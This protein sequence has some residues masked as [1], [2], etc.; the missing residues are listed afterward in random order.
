M[1]GVVLSP[2]AGF[3]VKSS[4]LQSAVYQPIEPDAAAPNSIEPVT[5]PIPVPQGQKVFINISWDQQ[6]PQPPEASEE[7]VRKA[8]M[9]EDEAWYVP[10]VVS[11]GRRDT[12]KAGKLS[13]VFD[14]IF[15]PSIKSRILRDPE[16]RL[17]IIEL[18]LQRI[19]AQTPLVLSR[20]IGTPNIAAKGKLLPRKVNLPSKKSVPS[21]TKP[22]IEEISASKPSTGLN[23]KGILKGLSAAEKSKPSWSWSNKDDRLE[24][25]ISVPKLASRQ[26]THSQ[27]PLTTLDLEPRRLILQVPGYE[28]MDINL[29]LSDAEIVATSGTTEY[30]ETEKSLLLKRQR[31]FDVEGAVSEWRAADGKLVLIA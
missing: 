5:G 22:L 28:T 23:P 25:T 17:F 29:N 2:T 26:L 20:E 21:T 27:I 31:R 15:H 19:E 1:A 13:L 30:S 11:E 18:A 4:T 7:V 12:D 3:C 8:M 24:I 14:C 10:V 16:F 9:G 6:V